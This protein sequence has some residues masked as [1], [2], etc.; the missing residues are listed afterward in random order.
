[1]PDPRR[2]SDEAAAK[3]FQMEPAHLPEVGVLA[4]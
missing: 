1:M 2:L 4:A 3:S